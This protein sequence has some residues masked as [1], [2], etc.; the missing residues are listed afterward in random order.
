L[1]LIPKK[2]DPSINLLFLR[3]DLQSFRISHIESQDILGNTNRITLESW[4]PKPGID[5]KLFQLEVPPG[6]KIFDPDGREF[7]PA[8]VEQ[9]KSRISSGK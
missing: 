7:P 5:P 2:E 1:K 8:E 3:I 4:T 6:S 9:L